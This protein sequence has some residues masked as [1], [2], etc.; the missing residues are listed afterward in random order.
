MSSVLF[1]VGNDI[2]PVS[3]FFVQN[4]ALFCIAFAMIFISSQNLKVH[5]KE[6]ICSI[7]IM[8]MA[9][10]LALFLYLER[11]SKEHNYAA[12][13]TVFGFFGYI[14]RPIVLVFF[15]RL[16]TAKR[17]KYHYVF[18]IPLV[19]NIIVYS[20]SL[21]MFSETLSHLVFYYET[22]DGVTT[23]MRGKLFLN[24]TAH[25][26]SACYLAYL[27]YISIKKLRGKH[28]SDAV[29]IM[30]CAFFVVVAVAVESIFS[31]EDIQLLNVTIAITALFYYLFL[32]TERTKCDPLTGLFNR[33]TYYSDI[34]K[35]GK[36]INGVIQLDMNGLKWINDNLGHLAGDK[37][38][39]ML[40]KVLEDSARRN[41]YVY[42]L[43]GDEFTI[44]TVACKEEEINGT[45]NSIKE[46]LSKTK[47]FCSIGYALKEDNDKSIEDTIKRAEV[48]MYHD[49][50]EFYKQ[51][52]F[53]RRKQDRLQD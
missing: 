48:R 8:A 35:L 1:A 3:A 9:I 29:T 38:L 52:K 12:A 53:E 16:V 2:N 17:P 11:Y 41:M 49:K 42:R 21:F 47:F 46:R 22:V 34:N 23:F 7:A 30:I 28:V 51:A 20:F 24:F 13:A 5:R 19:V 15:I 37:A 10:I 36:S 25:I 31:N 33:E 43:G 6:S 39:S 14:L 44:L 40:A 50:E 26:I 45:I 27:I 4:F 18:Y 32:Y